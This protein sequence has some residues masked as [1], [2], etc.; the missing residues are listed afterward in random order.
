MN[1]LL[2]FLTFFPCAPAAAAQPSKP[3]PDV[4]EAKY[5][6]DE[7]NVLDLWQA[8]SEGP[9][10]VVVYIH[11]GG[12][13]RGSKETLGED[14]LK[15]C[16]DAGISVAAINYRLTDSAPFPAAFL[17]SARAIQFLR[18]KAKEWN[19]DPKR[20]AA[21]GSSAGAG[22][23]LWIGFHD[24]MADPNSA[25]PVKRQSTRLTCMA[26]QGA[27]TTYDPR[28][29]KKLIGGRAHEHPSLL[30]FYGITAEEIDTPRAYELYEKASP[31]NYVTKDDPPV[32]LFYSEPKGPLPEDAKPGQGI[33]HPK[34]GIYLKKKME[35]LGIECVLRHRDDYKDKGMATELNREMVEFFLKHF[36]A[37]K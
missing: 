25:D 6:P 2:L 16:L 21:T 9:R 20:V 17:D 4:A 19:L 28:T 32:F 7:R 22:T 35:P 18:Y 34:F 3:K 23:S 11:G 36:K 8:R 12:F 24:D 37:V 30:P 10:P 31:I 27:Q 1:R 26:V 5:G 15:R 33:H 29:I 13:A 14:L